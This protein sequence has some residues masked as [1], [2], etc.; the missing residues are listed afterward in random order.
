MADWGVGVCLTFPLYDGGRRQGQM[1]TAAAQLEQARQKER[2]L[3]LGIRREA[4]TSLADWQS[5]VDRVK[6]LRQN[7]AEA[8]QV[9]INERLK[10]EAGRSVVNFVLDAEAALLTSQSLLAQARRSAEISRFSWQLA[11]GKLDP[12]D[13]MW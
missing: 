10:F 5:A 7:V 1:A 3:Q 6:S 13:L 4:Q 11:I 2:Q 9:L 12:S 8:E